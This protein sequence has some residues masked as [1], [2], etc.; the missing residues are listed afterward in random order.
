MPSI[1]I[2]TILIGILAVLCSAASP[3]PALQESDS[4][5]AEA[6][7]AHWR[8]DL[9]EAIALYDKVIARDPYHANAFFYRGAA[10]RSRG[11]HDA[12]LAD[13]NQALAI[14][15]DLAEALFG[16]GSIHRE[17]GLFDKTVADMDRVLVL[18]PKHQGAL[19]ARADAFYALGKMDE[20]IGDASTLIE[21]RPSLSEAHFYV[22]QHTR[23]KGM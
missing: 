8:W 21:I 5:F 9:E 4:T 1:K 15:P 3:L 13:F 10:H 2:W 6:V 17:R 14:Q 18:V 7:E 20:A 22:L 11:N 16:R 23:A 12:A 19:E